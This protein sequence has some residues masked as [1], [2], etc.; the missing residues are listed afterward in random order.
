[1]EAGFGM[2]GHGVGMCGRE[3][4]EFGCVWGWVC[5]CVGCVSL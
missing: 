2:G 3:G 1:M 4:G 5:V